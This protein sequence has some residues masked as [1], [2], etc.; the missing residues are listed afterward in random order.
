MGSKR[1]G[2]ITSIKLIFSVI[3]LSSHEDFYELS[4]IYHKE[5]YCGAYAYIYFFPKRMHV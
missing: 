5:R 1:L 3:C 4:L 2:I